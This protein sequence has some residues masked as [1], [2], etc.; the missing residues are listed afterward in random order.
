MPRA[1]VDNLGEQ[2]G[3]NSSSQWPPV[4]PVLSSLTLPW[5][6]RAFSLQG[7]GAT[8][9]DGSQLLLILHQNSASQL[10]FRDRIPLGHP[11]VTETIESKKGATRRMATGRGPGGRPPSHALADID[12][13]FRRR[14]CPCPSE[15]GE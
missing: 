11:A 13:P 15:R 7:A 5:L 4:R 1:T 10:H 8:A 3:S 2:K 6:I 9:L 14:R 12:V